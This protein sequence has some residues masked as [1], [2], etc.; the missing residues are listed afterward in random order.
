MKNIFQII[1]ISIG[2]LLGQTSEQIKKVK[3]VIQQRGMSES[4]AR[5]AAKAQGYTDQ[6][7]NSAIQKKKS[8]KSEVSKSAPESVENISLPELGNSNK[9]FQEKSMSENIELNLDEK[10]SVSGEDNLEVVERIQT[11]Y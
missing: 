6:Q 10:I 2:L 9:V 8:S 11:R 3:K 5:A 7:I 1:I 4:Q